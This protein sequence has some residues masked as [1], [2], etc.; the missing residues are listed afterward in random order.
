MCNRKLKGIAPEARAS[1]LAYDW[2]GNVRELE[3]MIERAV[4]L[5]TSD[6]IVPK[7]FSNIRFE[8]SLK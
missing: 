3:N 7:D 5:G 1:L 6:W 2:P 8:Q 4:V